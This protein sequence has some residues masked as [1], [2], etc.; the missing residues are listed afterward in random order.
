[1]ADA[2]RQ[3]GVSKVTYCLA[4]RIWRTEDR[5]GETVPTARDLRCVERCC[6]TAA[7]ARRSETSNCVRTVPSN[8]CAS[9]KGPGGC[10]TREP[11]RRGRY[12]WDMGSDCSPSALTQTAKLCAFG[13]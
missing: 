7:Q 13:S 4:P 9:K 1:M 6:P 2:I 3:I 12:R 5:A 11:L 8:A 10:A